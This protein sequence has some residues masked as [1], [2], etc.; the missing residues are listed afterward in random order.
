MAKPQQALTLTPI[1]VNYRN[2]AIVPC[3][4]GCGPINK[5]EHEYL[6]SSETGKYYADNVCLVNGNGDKLAAKGWVRTPLTVMTMDEYKS[7][8]GVIEHG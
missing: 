4:C 6:Y 7:E 3:G 2:P 5:D 8:L 1:P